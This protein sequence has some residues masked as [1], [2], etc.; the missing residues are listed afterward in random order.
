MRNK[1]L[2]LVPKL[3]EATPNPRLDLFG[4]KFGLPILAFVISFQVMSE[5]KGKNLSWGDAG[6]TLHIAVSE[7]WTQICNSRNPVTNLQARG[8]VVHQKLIDDGYIKES[9]KAK[10]TCDHIRVILGKPEFQHLFQ[11]V[12][13]VLRS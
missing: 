7:A 8:K 4:Q 5:D 10:A 9:R 12:C 11:D 13:F 3:R 1:L 6:S 2:G